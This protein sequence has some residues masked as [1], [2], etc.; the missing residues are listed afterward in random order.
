[1]PAA[2]SKNTPS[3]QDTPLDSLRLNASQ[4]RDVQGRLDRQIRKQVE[5]ELRSS[6][7]FSYRTQEPIE[8]RVTHP[9]ESSEVFR[10]RP[11]NLSGTG[12]GLLHGGF[13]HPG[14]ACEVM[15]ISQD[16]DLVGVSGVVVR[17]RHVEGRVHDIGIRFEEKLDLSMFEVEPEPDP[18]EYPGRG[19]GGELLRLESEL[20]TNRAIRQMLP[21]Y[22]DRLKAMVLQLVQSLRARR[23]TD[24]ISLC[25]ELQLLARTSGYPSIAEQAGDLHARVC[26]GESIEQ[27]R[28]GLIRLAALCDGAERGLTPG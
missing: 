19:A 3:P 28:G 9:G 5:R 6:E 10:V 24:A 25:A 16:G 20:W 21:S 18:D 17:C 14:S 1:M 2:T 26:R 23:S 8:M 27:W 22:V 15:M 13:L 7:R 12:L 4:H 11:R